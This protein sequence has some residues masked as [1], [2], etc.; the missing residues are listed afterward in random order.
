MAFVLW[1]AIAYGL[2]LKAFTLHNACVVVKSLCSVSLHHHQA[3]AE[4]AQILSIPLWPCFHHPVW[5][6]GG[7]HRGQGYSQGACWLPLP[8]SSVRTGCWTWGKVVGPIV[9]ILVD[10]LRNHCQDK[11]TYFISESD[12]LTTELWEQAAHI[13]LGAFSWLDLLLPA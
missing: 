1:W 12:I 13:I 2:G 7:Q 11:G 10:T 4:H 5:L 9:T 3:L 8:D 6:L